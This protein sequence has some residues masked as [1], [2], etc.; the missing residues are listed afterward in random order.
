MNTSTIPTLNVLVKETEICPLGCIY[1]YEGEKSDSVMT[2]TTLDNML[3]LILLRDGAEST[4]FIWHGAEPL[5]RGIEFYRR[6][7]DTQARYKTH[8]VANGVQT[9]GVLLTEEWADFLSSN[10]ISTGFSLDGPQHVHDKTR[11]FKSGVG[12]FQEVM[13]AIQLMKER[14]QSIGVI[15]VLSRTSLPHLDEI[16]DFF[17]AEHLDFKLNPLIYAGSATGNPLVR[18]SADE[19]VY[20]MCHMFDRWFFDTTNKGDSTNYTSAIATAR[21]MFMGV[22]GA[23][24]LSRNCQLSFISIGA[25][26]AVYPCSRFSD[27]A[28]SY[29]NINEVDSFSDIASNC[30]RQRLLQRFEANEKCGQCDYSPLCF[31]GC[32]HSAYVNGDIMGRDP[33]CVVYRRVY[34]HVASRIMDELRKCGAINTKKN[35]EG[36]KNERRL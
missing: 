10:G 15:A 24:N 1:C 21:A 31:S 28:V 7:L 32:L 34:D 14:G 29:G 27:P 16:Y 36:D 18:L 3:R 33:N 22:H 13:R 6:A 17:R 25:D 12:S 4:K 9:S 23:C 20:A 2:E 19:V 5:T 35:T 8:K 26:G 30:L 11:P